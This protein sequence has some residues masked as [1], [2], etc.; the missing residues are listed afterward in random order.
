MS[1]SLRTLVAVLLLIATASA[2]AHT[3]G[4]SFLALQAQDGSTI[5]AEWDFDV[6]DLHRSFG[7]D[8]D[9]DGAVSWGEIAG[10]N[11]T[12]EALVLARTPLSSADQQCRGT[13]RDAPALAEHDDGPYLRLFLTFSCPGATRSLTLDHS[14]WFDFDAGH[15]ALLDYQAADGERSQAILS[16]AAPQWHTT[17]PRWSHLLRF[18]QEGMHHLVTGYDHLA[19]LGILLLALVRRPRSGQP[20]SLGQ[21]TR[22]AVAV[23]TAFTIAHSV[24]LMLA[25]TGHVNLPSQPVEVTIAASVLLASL[26][27]LRTGAAAHGWK[28]AFGFGLVHGLGFAGALAELTSERIDLFALAAFN[29]GIEAAQ[30]AIALAVVPLLW[31]LCRDLRTERIGVPLASLAVAGL[32][33][34]WV[35]MRVTG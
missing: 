1:A 33:A 6:R 25:A 17:Q 22:R 24:T 34:V 10:A 28:L 15:R 32:A 2:H 13:T 8:A 14:G 3:S 5:Q 9:A 35:G 20:I 29:V 12:I 19:F 31:W 23:I 7:L 21:T 11:E 4:S 27:N 26:M 18:L 30:I 16:K